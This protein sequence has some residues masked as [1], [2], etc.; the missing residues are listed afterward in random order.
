MRTSK[1]TPKCMQ[2]H[3]DWNQ[4]RAIWWWVC[5]FVHDHPVPLWSTGAWK[6]IWFVVNSWDCCIHINTRQSIPDTCQQWFI[7]GIICCGPKLKTNL[8]NLFQ[9]YLLVLVHVNIIDISYEFLSFVGVRWPWYEM[10]A[11]TDYVPLLLNYFSLFIMVG[12]GLTCN[13]IPLLF[14]F[15]CPSTGRH[16]HEPPSYLTQPTAHIPDCHA[17]GGCWHRVKSVRY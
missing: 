10:T 8:C 12:D 11:S 14:R 2:V 6:T 16:P 15:F 1:K 3:V 7:I 13:G 5:Q 4:M 17:R 9:L